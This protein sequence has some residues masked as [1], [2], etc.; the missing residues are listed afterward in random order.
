MP[1]NG[2]GVYSK[3][4]GTTAVAN[5]TIE[6]AK[7]NATIDDLV[8]DANTARPITAGGT[9]ATSIAGF[10]TSFSIGTLASQDA[11][12]VTITGGTVDAVDITGGTIDEAAVTGGTIDAA[13][14]SNG[15]IDGAD[16]S[17]GTIDEAAVT[18]GTID[19]ATITGGTITGG[20][21]ADA[22]ISG[23]VFPRSS[24]LS[25]TSVTVSSGVDVTLTSVDSLTEYYADVSLITDETNIVLPDPSTL[26]HGWSVCVRS[27]GLVAAY[28][29]LAVVTHN[30]SAIIDLGGHD[31][32]YLPIVGAGCILDIVWESEA[33]RFRVVVIRNVPRGTYWVTQRFNGDMYDRSLA[34]GVWTAVGLDTYTGPLATI[35][36]TTVPWPGLWVLRAKCRLFTAAGTMMPFYTGIGDASNPFRWAGYTDD[37]PGAEGVIYIG[38]DYVTLNYAHINAD[39]PQYIGRGV[40]ARQYVYV[41]E[42]TGADGR[43][44]P[45]YSHCR[46]EFAGYPA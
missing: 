44:Y 45:G 19:G 33:S 41:S 12:A 32:S 23:G 20:T 8:T 5:T 28:T 17:N 22:T 27:N 7:Y 29:G 43:F 18:G 14:I 9:G 42:G 35:T 37:T 13:A 31:I 10:K 34:S 15:T 6:S 39:A 11:D 4:A 40:T 21:I 16:I 36:M 1:R 46:L 26:S 38:S 24:V 30:G 2:S 3:P 25:G